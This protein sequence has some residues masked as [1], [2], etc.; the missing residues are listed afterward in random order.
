LEHGWRWCRRNP[1][2][3]LLGSALLLAMLIIVIGLIAG[4][5]QIQAHYD[6][7]VEEKGKAEQALKE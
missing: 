2:H 3:A 4:S 5:W 7:A 6:K 1:A